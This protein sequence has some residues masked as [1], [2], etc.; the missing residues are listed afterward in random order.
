MSQPLDY[1]LTHFYWSQYYFFSSGKGF[2]K[3]RLLAVFWGKKTPKHQILPLAV[4]PITRPI[5][6]NWHWPSLWSCFMTKLRI[7][8]VKPGLLVSLSFSK[9]W[10]AKIPKETTEK[11]M[12]QRVK[13]NERRAKSEGRVKLQHTSF[14]AS[15]HYLRLSFFCRFLSHVVIRRQGL[16]SVIYA[17]VS[18]ARKIMA[19][20]QTKNFTQANQRKKQNQ[21]QTYTRYNIFSKSLRN[22]FLWRGWPY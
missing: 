2:Q 12:E 22:N 9:S 18:S 8:V 1:A 6:S 20:P 5:S 10:S 15:G 4:F 11:G 7:L 14:L 21:S 17:N 19:P 16:G 3:F 13:A